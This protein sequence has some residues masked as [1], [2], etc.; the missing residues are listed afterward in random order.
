MANKTTIMRT[1]NSHLFEFLDDVLRIFPENLDIQTAKN[2]LVAIKQANQTIIIK[3]WL[4]HV[5]IPYKEIIDRGDMDFFFK[6]DYSSDL[7]DMSNRN[8]V[9]QVIDKLR[10]SVLKM[11]DQQKQFT[12]DYIK[13]LSKLSVAYA[14]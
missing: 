13:N 3:T 9:M 5:Y 6:K 4:Q 14:V 11:T 1:F 8:E 12:A 10:D 7:A 2:A